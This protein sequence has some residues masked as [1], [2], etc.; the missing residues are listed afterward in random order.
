MPVVAGAG[1]ALSGDCPA[2]RA[3]TGLKYVKQPEPHGLLAIG[4]ALDLDV[5]AVPENVEAVPLRVE[6]ALPA[7][8]TRPGE[9]RGGLVTQRRAGTQARP[10]VRQVLHDAQLLAGPQATDDG[11]ARQI[12]ARLGTDLDAAWYVDV[13]VHRRGHHQAAV[14]RLVYQQ[15]PAFGGL[16]PDRLERVAQ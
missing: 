14:P 8:V 10:A 12:L 16:M 15:R 5:G 4:I 1:E 7:G 11:G 13:M 3:R 6:Q 2:F 9:R